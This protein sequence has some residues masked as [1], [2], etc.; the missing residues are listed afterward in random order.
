M[1]TCEALHIVL[2]HYAAN[3][4]VRYIDPDGR[5]AQFVIGAITGAAI[6]FVSSVVVQG[7]AN[8]AVGKSITDIDWKS[9]GTST[10]GGAISGAI[11]GGIS[12]LA[13]AK[14]L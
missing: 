1:Q 3:S 7:V 13:A 4:P 2:Y 9:V 8:A 6:G 10:L 14:M 11:I 12:G 5:V